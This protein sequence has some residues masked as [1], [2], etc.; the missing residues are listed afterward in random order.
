MTDETDDLTIPEGEDHDEA[1]DAMT[2]RDDI[3]GR[4]HTIGEL[5]AWELWENAQGKLEGLRKLLLGIGLHHVIDEEIASI[6]RELDQFSYDQGF[7]NEDGSD[8][9]DAELPGFNDWYAAQ[10]DNHHAD[11]MTYLELREEY[12]GLI[13]L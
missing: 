1:I 3:L 13:N 12:R 11:F 6:G 10:I 5:D 9:D 2:F 8:P 7:A 4:E